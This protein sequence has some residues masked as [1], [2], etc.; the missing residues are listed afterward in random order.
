ML[1]STPSEECDLEPVEA[2]AMET[3]LVPR[4]VEGLAGARE[5][6]GAAQGQSGDLG[7]CQ[8]RRSWPNI[9]ASLE[10]CA[11]VGPK[12]GSKQILRASLATA[13]WARRPEAQACQYRSGLHMARTCC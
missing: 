4:L 5:R 12:P 8:H 9:A 1:V 10:E 2:C 6:A 13:R 7:L 3:V 11:D